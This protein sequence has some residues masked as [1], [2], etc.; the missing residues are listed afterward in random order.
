MYI[1]AGLVVDNSLGESNKHTLA[2][3]NKFLVCTGPAWTR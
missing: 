2:Q 1:I 3:K